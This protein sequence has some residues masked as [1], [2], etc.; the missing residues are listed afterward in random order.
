M[1]NEPLNLSRFTVD[2]ILTL[3]ICTCERSVPK[4]YP[5][6]SYW[7]E[8]R[9]T[10]SFLIF[11]AV[12]LMIKNSLVVWSQ[13][14]YNGFLIR[15]WDQLSN[16]ARAIFSTGEISNE[17]FEDLMLICFFRKGIVFFQK[18]NCPLRI[19]FYRTNCKPSFLK[20]PW[21]VRRKGNSCKTQHC[22][23]IS[24]PYVSMLTPLQKFCLLRHSW[25]SPVP[26]F[27]WPRSLGLFLFPKLKNVRKDRHFG[28]ISKRVYILKI[29]PVDTKVSTRSPSLCSYLR[30]LIWWG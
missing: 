9:S 3:N 7:A 2:Q 23:Q 1:L 27:T 16:W 26:L 5:K 28:R 25:G 4:R 13:V 21:E 15:F 29:I 10:T 8:G 6:S 14:M 20:H 17:Q 24:S 30:K 18:T 19:C 22:R 12:S 11:L